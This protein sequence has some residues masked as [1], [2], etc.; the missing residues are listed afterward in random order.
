MTKNCR[1]TEVLLAAGYSSDEAKVRQFE[2][3]GVRG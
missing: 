1:L 3:A 2:V